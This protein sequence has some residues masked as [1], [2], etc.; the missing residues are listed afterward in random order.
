MTV[1]RLFAFVA[2]LLAPVAAMAQGLG[3]SAQ[4]V[5][6]ILVGSGM[7]E[8]ADAEAQLR[9]KG[10]IEVRGPR[11]RDPS[12]GAGHVKVDLLGDRSNLAALH[13]QIGLMGAH[14]ADYL[15][16]AGNLLTLLAPT[17]GDPPA[18][19]KDMP[20]PRSESR[21]LVQFVSE[22]SYGYYAGTF[23]LLRRMGGKQVLFISPGSPFPT[24][25]VRPDTGT[26]L[27]L[28]R[29]P[30][31]ANPE[32]VK[33]AA[34]FENARYQ[35][36]LDRLTPLAEAGDPDAQAMLGEVYYVGRGLKR[37]E[38][39]A[40]TWFER[41]ATKGNAHG[42]FG[43]GVL[44]RGAERSKD[45]LRAMEWFRK[46]ALQGHAQAQFLLAGYYGRKAAGRKDGEA[47]KW[48][49]ISAR[50]GNVMGQYCLMTA[51]AA[52]NGTQRNNMEAQFWFAVSRR[53][54]PA[55]EGFWLDLAKKELSAQ[56]SPAQRSEVQ[57]RAEAWRPLT[58]DEIKR[59]CG[60]ID[61]PAELV[62]S[63][64]AGATGTK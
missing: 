37:D 61:C 31:P 30:P 40:R 7:I 49:G 11:D 22:A 13:V 9:D 24:I 60:E 18:W 19:T 55:L 46:A 41:A 64:K 42:Q 20:D 54:Y 63:I 10:L 44:A 33:V 3:V 47:T 1:V 34:D 28:F 45:D 8:R 17:P 51:L 56:L 25:D 5:I 23:F 14:T 35:A 36:A 57:R 39:A 12:G 43:M 53:T 62:A 27:D 50:L 16:L 21:W 52:G 6:D 26:A 4:Q 29:R 58:F 32:L 48:C 59:R 2:C 38:D 15:V